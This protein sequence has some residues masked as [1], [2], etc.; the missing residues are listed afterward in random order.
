MRIHQIIQSVNNPSAGPTYSVARLA[1]ELHKLGE[2]ASVLTL[3][4]PPAQWPYETPLKIHDGLLE[5]KTGVSLSLMRE[6]RKHAETSCILHGHGIWR[7][8]N[9]FPLFVP[10]HAPGRLVCSP[11][12]MLSPWSMRYKSIMKQPF[13]RFLQKPA[14]QRC[15]CFHVTAA[16]EL[17]DIRRVGLRSPV[18]VI[19][20]GVDLPLLPNDMPREKRI[21]FLSRIDPKKGLDLL[22]PAWTATAPQFSD[23][24][25]VIAGPLKG[26]YADS[27]QTLA[28]D[29]HAPRVRFT[30][31]ILGEA[32]RSLLSGASLFVLPTYSENFGIAVAE[33]L[34]HGVPVITTTETPWTEIGQ[35]NCGWCIPPE[36]KALRAA[37]REALSLPLPALHEMGENGRSWMQRDYAWDRIAEMM[38]QT[39]EW[40]FHRGAQPGWVAMM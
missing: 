18:A 22:L 39:Y 38:R 34:A 40:L 15:H 9:L 35:R 37:L 7:L 10:R 13:W 36:E 17:E 33:A 23:W 16:V 14:L 30:G 12:G 2:E 24:E 29:I 32:K 26:S 11:R 4:Q 5:R 25:L 1:G 31:E 6:I 3:G 8:A 19:P 20:N 28:R 27:I 21:V